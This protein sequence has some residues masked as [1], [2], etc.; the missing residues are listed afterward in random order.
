MIRTNERSAE[1]CINDVKSLQNQR[2]EAGALLQKHSKYPLAR[3][4]GLEI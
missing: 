2:D 1:R 4:L 3:V